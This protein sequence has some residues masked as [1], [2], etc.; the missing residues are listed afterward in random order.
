LYLAGRPHGEKVL[1]PKG[2][3]QATMTRSPG[4]LLAKVYQR[5]ILSPISIGF[6]LAGFL[7]KLIMGFFIISHL[8]LL[9]SQRQLTKTFQ[10]FSSMDGKSARK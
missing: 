5:D 3:G 10:F 1:S 7:M 6:Y 8:S 9:G 2:S 4:E